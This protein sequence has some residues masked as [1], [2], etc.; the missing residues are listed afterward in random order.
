MYPM[1]MQIMQI[2]QIINML[3]TMSWSSHM[4]SF[5]VTLREGRDPSTNHFQEP[6]QD[7]FGFDETIIWL[8]NTT[9]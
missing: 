7:Y 5:H 2:M 3:Y 1:C 8:T 9:N 4:I 6:L